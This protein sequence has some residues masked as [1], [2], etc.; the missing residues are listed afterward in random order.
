MRVARGTGKRSA[1]VEA[2][3]HKKSDS[4]IFGWRWCDGAAIGVVRA[5]RPSRTLRATHCGFSGSA[6]VG[7]D[8]LADGAARQKFAAIDSRTKGNEG[9]LRRL[10]S[11]TARGQVFGRVRRRNLRLRRVGREPREPLEP[12]RAARRRP[13]GVPWLRWTSSAT[14]GPGGARDAPFLPA[15]ATCRPRLSLVR[16]RGRG[17]ADE[18]RSKLSAPRTRGQS[19]SIASRKALSTSR[20][21]DR[22]VSL[23]RSNMFRGRGARARTIADAPRDTAAR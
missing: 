4:F 8:A 10:G 2:T 22:H 19:S 13:R 21:A 11:S 5:S 15:R 16:R 23:L 7:C 17:R 1:C 3:P 9:V 14:T 20:R 6:R 12:P 18:S